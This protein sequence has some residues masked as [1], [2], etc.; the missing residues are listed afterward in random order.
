[1]DLFNG[2]F[3]ARLPLFDGIRTA[4]AFQPDDAVRVNN[5]V[6]RNDNDLKRLGSKAVGGQDQSYIRRFAQRGPT[7]RVVAE[8]MQ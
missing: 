2:V 6:L 4:D 5:P 1:M 8:K 7:G 3:H